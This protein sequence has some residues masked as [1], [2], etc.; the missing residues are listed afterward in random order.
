MGPGAAYIIRIFF[1]LEFAPSNGDIY[2][3]VL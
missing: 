2:R 3:L 1:V